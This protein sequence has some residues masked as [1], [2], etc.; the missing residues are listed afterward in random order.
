MPA[1][2][3]FYRTQKEVLGFGRDGYI[4]IFDNGLNQEDEWMMGSEARY[5]RCWGWY[6]G[7]FAELPK[8]LPSE[9]RS[10]RLDWTSVGTENGTLKKEDDVIAAVNNAIYPTDKSQYVGKVGERLDLALTVDRA[11]TATTKYGSSTIHY[12]SDAD[13][14]IFV[15]ATSAKNWPV[16]SSHHLRGTVKE[17]SN[18]I[19]HLTR[20]MEAK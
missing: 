9:Y 2:P 12:M 19:T 4:T 7:D 17:H 18:N 13:G 3:N 15:W 20:C 1:Q 14:N 10:V 11:K 5:A 8:D 16:G 6:F